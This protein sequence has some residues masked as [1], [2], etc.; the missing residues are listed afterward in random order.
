MFLKRLWLS[1]KLLWMDKV[2]YTH[3]AKKYMYSLKETKDKNKYSFNLK[4][5]KK[6]CYWGPRVAE[7]E[8]RLGK[9]G[10]K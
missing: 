3:W 4:A 1:L 2:I 5:Y 7:L 10:K 8:S 6:L 9:G